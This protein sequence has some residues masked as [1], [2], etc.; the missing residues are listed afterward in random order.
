LIK[1]SKRVTKYRVRLGNFL[2]GLGMQKMSKI[3]SLLVEVGL[4]WSI[5]GFELY[6]QTVPDSAGIA[7]QMN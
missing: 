4:E 1:N 7:W 2:R 6:R 5:D 3:M